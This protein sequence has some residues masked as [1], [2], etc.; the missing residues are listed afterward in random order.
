VPARRLIGQF[1]LVDAQTEMGLAIRGIAAPG[2]IPGRR[3]VATSPDSVQL[4]GSG[5]VVIHSIHLQQPESWSGVNLAPEQAVASS[6]RF[7][8]MAVVE[9]TLVRAFHL[10]FRGLRHAIEK[11]D[12]CQWH[13][14][15]TAMK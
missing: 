2:R 3:A 14:I 10:P 7:L 11:R 9:Q 12:A 5:D 6:C 1:H 4:L 15:E 8:G 13:P